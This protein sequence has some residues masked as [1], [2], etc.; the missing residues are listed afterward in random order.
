MTESDHKDMA[1]FPTPPSLKQEQDMALLPTPPSLKQEQ[2]VVSLM[3]TF[4]FCI[5]N[6]VHVWCFSG[7]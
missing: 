5:H 6:Y 7:S 2:E 1:L 3:I 4:F